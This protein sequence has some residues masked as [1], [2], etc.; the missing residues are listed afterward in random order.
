M[1]QSRLS[2]QWE[3]RLPLNSITWKLADD[4][5][6]LLEPELEKQ[7]SQVWNEI[8]KKYPSSYDGRLLVLKNFQVSSSG[9]H[10]SVGVIAFSRVITL[11]RLRHAQGSHST[12]GFQT[13]VLSPDRRHILVGVRS[14]ES[15]YCPSYLTTP[16][17]MLEAEDVKGSVEAAFMRELKE[18]V[19]LEVAPEKYL[20]ALVSNVKGVSGANLLIEATASS[21]VNP[22]KWMS[23]NEEWEGH[24][25]RWLPVEDLKNLD[26]KHALEGLVFAA[27][28]W[29]RHLTSGN[30]V[31]WQ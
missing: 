24:R 2:V 28:Q 17:G 15:M 13:I 11:M 29:H 7:K 30:S 4:N 6:I 31:L 8:L 22:K 5:E 20:L 9:A 12:L 14:Q 27:E 3:G 1:H 25:L 19:Q 26:T 23:G 18:E 16:G 21:R 10:F